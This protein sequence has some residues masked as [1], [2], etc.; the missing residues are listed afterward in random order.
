MDELIQYV[1]GFLLTPD[2]QQVALVSKNRPEWPV[3][4]LNG[5]GGKL[6]ANELPRQAITR[7]FA[8]ETGVQIAQK[9]W[10][11]LARLEGSNFQVYFFFAVSEKALE[12]ATKTDGQVAL[13]PVEQLFQLP[14]I[15]NVRWL[16][17]LALDKRV[18]LP[19]VFEELPV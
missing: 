3:N 5:V 11:A 12:V 15:P 9:D 10:Q 14:V 6:E 1:A 4:L 8:E 2:Q 16:I 7:E 19:I 17:P 13:Y 18:R